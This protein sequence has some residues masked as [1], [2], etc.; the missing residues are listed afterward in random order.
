MSELRCKPW[1]PLTSRKRMQLTC[2]IE[3]TGIFDQA[4]KSP[5]FSTR[6]QSVQF[7]CF[8]P[9][10]SIS[11]LLVGVKNSIKT[12]QMKNSEQTPSLSGLLNEAAPSEWFLSGQT[13]ENGPVVEIPIHSDRFSVGRKS[14]ASLQLNVGSVSSKHAEIEISS[15]GTSLILRDLGSTNGTFL[16]GIQVRGEVTAHEGDLVQF[17]SL[18][19]RI[20]AT[21]EKKQSNTV[22]AAEVTHERALSMMQFDRLISEGGVFPH[23]QPLVTLHDQNVFGY[24]VLGRSK[25]FGLQSPVEMFYAAG[26]L[27]LEA[28]LSEVFRFQGVMKA[29]ELPATQNLFVNTHP[30]ELGQPRL[31]ESLKRVREMAPDRLVTLEIHEAATTDLRMMLELRE[32]LDDL[33]IQLAFDDFGVGQA[34]LVELAEVRPEYLKFDMQLTKNL[35]HAPPKRQEVV[36]LFAKMVKDLGIKTLA[37]GVETRACHEMLLEMGFDMGQGFFYGKPKSISHFLLEKNDGDAPS[38]LANESQASQAEAEE[39]SDSP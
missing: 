22:A 19:F 10:E 39:N 3:T 16:N 23:Y 15:N 4:S 12:L 29:A 34:R 32:V 28:E 11:D 18:V 7:L 38:E 20:L 26:Q 36:G 33:N 17:A 24:E 31:Y 30:K 6:K 2:T 37:E 8:A 35:E 14:G 13:T 5:I 21:A 27:D 1:K 25:L 9:P